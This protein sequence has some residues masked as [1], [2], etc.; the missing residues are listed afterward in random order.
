MRQLYYY[1]PINLNYVCRFLSKLQLQLPPSLENEQEVGQPHGPV[2]S[3]SS[4]FWN[5]IVKI[6]RKTFH[7]KKLRRRKQPESRKPH[8]IKVSWFKNYLILWYHFRKSESTKAKTSS[9]PW[10]SRLTAKPKEMYNK[11][12]FLSSP[13]VL[14]SLSNLIIIMV[15]YC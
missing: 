11:S 13:S 3:A 8:T 1:L 15:L 14:L 7:I 12:R 10:V 4:R 6:S 9:N 5:S 2:A